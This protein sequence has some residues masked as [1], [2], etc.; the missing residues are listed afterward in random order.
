MGV[1]ES[2]VCPRELAYGV[3]ASDIDLV[4]PRGAARRD[5]AGA[6]AEQALSPLK[7][8]DLTVYCGVER[9]TA[10]VLSRTQLGGGLWL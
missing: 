2:T 10:S 1:R 5:R 9:K 3:D 4:S 8:P 6:M 7:I